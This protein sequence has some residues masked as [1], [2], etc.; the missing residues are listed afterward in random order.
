VLSALF[1]RRDVAFTAA[2]LVVLGGVWGVPR[3]LAAGDSVR[4]EV[5]G[6][7]VLTTASTYRI[8]LRGNGADDVCRVQETAGRASDSKAPFALPVSPAA[9]KAGGGR[10]TFQA[11]GCDNA[12]L[13]STKVA[14]EVPVHVISA[15]TYVA[16][17]SVEASLR[18]FSLKVEAV[19]GPLRARITRGGKTVAQLASADGAKGSWT[20]KPGR[21]PAG[22]Y[23]AEVTAGR[24]SSSRTLVVPFTVTS[25]WA[26]LGKPFPRCQLLTW[27]YDDTGEPGRAQGISKDVATAF[28]RISKA[29]GIRFKHVADD[30]T[31]ELGWKDMGADGPDGEGGAFWSGDSATSGRIVFNTHSTWV[32]KAGFTRYDADFPG[33]GALV[34]H[35]IGHALGLGHVTDSAQ[36]MYPVATDGSPLGLEQGDRAGLNALYHAKSC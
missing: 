12:L 9:L 18:K 29:T 20:W 11:V 22:H 23:R 30:G 10:L 13:G 5:A 31:I 17:D 14:V 16:P 28:T 21:N 4:L 25:H 24:G 36:V 1:H 27:S 3:S 32:G 34:T 35:E 8:T 26:P 19:K 6:P 2:A 33:R 15:G 7:A